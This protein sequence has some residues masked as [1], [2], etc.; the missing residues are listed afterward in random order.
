MP[1]RV[2][3]D[4]AAHCSVARTR[5]SDSEV[6]VAGGAA[7]PPATSDSAESGCSGQPDVLI[8]AKGPQAQAVDTA[9]GSHQPA[10]D[11]VDTGSAPNNKL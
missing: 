7:A 11:S 1:G 9:S 5:G 10:T 2:Y 6:T 4:Q 8:M 3:H